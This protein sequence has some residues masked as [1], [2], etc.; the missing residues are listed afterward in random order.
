MTI[1]DHEDPSQ[2]TPAKPRRSLQ[3]MQIEA[4]IN[5][6]VGRLECTACGC[7]NFQVTSSWILHGVRKRIRRCRSCGMPLTTMEISVS[8]EFGLE[9]QKENI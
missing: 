2:E 4:L 3:R 8:E 5:E 6:G 9:Q 1:E 7:K